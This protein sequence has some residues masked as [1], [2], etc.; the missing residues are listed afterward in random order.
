[1]HG[2]GGVVFHDVT[3]ARHAQ[4]AAEAGVDGLILVAGGAGGHAGTWNPFALLGEVR[5]FFHGT[6]VLAG[7]ISTGRD[8]AAAQ[9]LGA[10]LAYMGTRF[11][12]TQESMAPPA[13]KQMMVEASA[14]DIVY[15]ASICTVPASFLRAS[16]AAAGLDPDDVVRRGE[17]DLGHVTQPY[18]KELE[19][20]PAKPWRDIW[21]AGQGVGTVDDIPPAGTLIA[22]LVAQYRDA[23]SAFAG[24]SA[25]FRGAATDADLRGIE[26]SP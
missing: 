18:R 17:V 2:Y 13:Y 10:D 23:V 21:S 6:V 5:R 4:K 24:A 22:A 16:I 3:N 9:M 8:I 7:G 1:V 20:L 15:T 26:A 14:A 12:A 25:P 11:N 19:A